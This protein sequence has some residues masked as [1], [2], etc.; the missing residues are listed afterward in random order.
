MY[1]L[2]ME[3]T[4]QFQPEIKPHMAS[5]SKESRIAAIFFGCF[6]LLAI[7]IV[8]F[9]YYQNQQLKGM[10]AKYTAPS[11]TPIDIKD[12]LANWKMIVNSTYNYQVR[13]PQE[14]KELTPTSFQSPDGLYK[15]TVSTE[16]NKNKVTGKPYKSLDEYVG[17]PYTV[18]TLIVDNQD[19]RQ[20][21]P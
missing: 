7:G 10:L 14:W 18:K 17:L 2:K 5:V 8:A 21:L 3:P 16:V 19:A 1:T 11:P 6:I 9:F 13:V 20:P 12:P 4:N 15:F